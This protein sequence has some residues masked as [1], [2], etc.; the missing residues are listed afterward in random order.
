MS[1]LTDTVNI[2]CALIQGFFMNVAEYQKENEYKTVS[3][4]YEPLKVKQNQ[5]FFSFYS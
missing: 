1:T 5:T 3:R 2:R 4:L